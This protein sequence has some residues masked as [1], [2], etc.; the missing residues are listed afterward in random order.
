[1]TNGRRELAQFVLN[2]E[3]SPLDCLRAVIAYFKMNS[4]YHQEA[5][6]LEAM[7]NHGDWPW[8]S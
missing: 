3:N 6:K 5:T 2:E 8:V 1:M 4:E 7:L